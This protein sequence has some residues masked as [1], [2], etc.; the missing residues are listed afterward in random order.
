MATETVSLNVVGSLRS[1]TLSVKVEGAKRA[2]LRLWLAGHLFRF[3]GWVSGCGVVVEAGQSPRED[4]WPGRHAAAKRIAEAEVARRYGGAH[5]PDSPVA[6]RPAPPTGG[7]GVKRPPLHCDWCGTREGS[8][9]HDGCR[10]LLPSPA[11]KPNNN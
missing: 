6:A 8:L 5:S 7:S 3:A 2:S 10:H 9:H 4:G 11:A 1:V